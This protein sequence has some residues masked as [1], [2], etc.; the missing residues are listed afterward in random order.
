[1]RTPPGVGAL[2]EDRGTL[3]DV[4]ARA[5]WPREPRHHAANCICV[6]RFEVGRVGQVVAAATAC[7]MVASWSKLPPS[8]CQRSASSRAWLA[9]PG[10][11]R[12]LV[13]VVSSVAHRA[14][15]RQHVS[16]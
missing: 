4:A 1:M 7:G 8:S 15:Q 2:R 14:P 3:D 9:A 11:T 16:S 13:G 10:M 5:V 12:S 6:H